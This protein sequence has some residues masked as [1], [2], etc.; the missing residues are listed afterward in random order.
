MGAQ[1]GALPRRLGT[2]LVSSQSS[3]LQEGDAGTP[4]P[5]PLRSPSSLLTFC[6]LP[7]PQE[8]LL[9]LE[10]HANWGFKG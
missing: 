9:G 1:G 5:P 2:V 7:P 10:V 3:S 4:T 6:L 8:T